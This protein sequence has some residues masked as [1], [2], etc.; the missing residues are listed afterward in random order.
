ARVVSRFIVQALKG[1]P[2]TVH[3]DGRQTR[4]FLYVADAVEALVK[5]MVKEGLRG[6][7]VNVGSPREVTILELAELIKRLTGSGSPIVLEPPRPDDPRR[8]CPDISKARKL[9]GWEPRTPLEEGLKLTIKW[10]EEVL[11]RGK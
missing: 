6:E 5:M 4:S 8:R 1:Q 11:S 2:I 7:V 3:G 10:F 9:L